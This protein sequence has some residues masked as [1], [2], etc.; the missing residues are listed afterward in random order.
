VYL[1]GMTSYHADPLALMSV[2]V[3]V[4]ESGRASENHHVLFRVLPRVGEFVTLETTGEYLKVDH[5]LHCPSH[6]QPRKYD[7]EIWVHREQ[8]NFSS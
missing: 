3:H 7:A 5:V 8:P 6:L 4:K 2:F 1:F